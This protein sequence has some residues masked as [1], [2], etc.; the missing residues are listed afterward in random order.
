MSDRV[1]HDHPTIETIPATI[2]RF[3]RTTRP[4]IRIGEEIDLE[5]GTIIHLVLGGTELRAMVEQRG[6][7]LA[8]RGAYKTP[9]M[10]RNPGSGEN[11]LESWVAERDLE[12]GRTVH[13]DVVEPGY[14][15][16]LRAPGESGTYTTGRPDSG[17]ADIAEK[18]GVE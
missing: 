18:F 2:G 10:A 6:G 15:Y 17:L 11:H 16:G 8:I 1:A 12:P 5:E 4:E 13:L 3:G 9:R 7:S 14:K